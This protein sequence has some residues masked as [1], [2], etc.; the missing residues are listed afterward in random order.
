MESGN[1]DGRVRES[2]SAFREPILDLCWG[3]LATR[4]A[5]HEHSR[6]AHSP[7]L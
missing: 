4:N 2:V 6:V 3:L 1:D 5:R 7:G